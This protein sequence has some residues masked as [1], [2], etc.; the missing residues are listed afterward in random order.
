MLSQD[1]YIIKKMTKFL[2]FEFTVNDHNSKLHVPDNTR[3]KYVNMVKT[4]R[5]K[6]IF[7]I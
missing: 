4:A 2:R 1:K 6:I 7:Q 3:S 5:K